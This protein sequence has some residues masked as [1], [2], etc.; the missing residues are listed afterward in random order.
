MELVLVCATCSSRGF[1]DLVEDD[2]VGV[3]LSVALRIQ[4]HCLVCPEVCHCDL[5]ILRAAVDAVDH[6]VVVEVTKACIAIRA[7]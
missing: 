7:T 5:G 3:D 2:P 6:L 1:S 4:H